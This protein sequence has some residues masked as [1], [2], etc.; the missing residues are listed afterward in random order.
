MAIE[1]AV[2]QAGF[3]H[4]H[5]NDLS[6][7]HNLD[8]AAN[9]LRP[10]V[11]SSNPAPLPPDKNTASR[12]GLCASGRAASCGSPCAGRAV[13]AGYWLLAEED[14]ERCWGRV[15]G[16]LLMACGFWVH[17]MREGCHV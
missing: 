12:T 11:G 4:V 10:I 8:P 9:P 3:I 5:F 7:A 14:A 15:K 2:M 6:T 1:R 17:C 13:A 16:G